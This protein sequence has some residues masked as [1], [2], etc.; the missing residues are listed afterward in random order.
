[1]RGKRLGIAV[2][3]AIVSMLIW[4]TGVVAQDPGFVP[5][6]SDKMKYPEF[7][8]PF[9]PSKPIP[10]SAITRIA[11][12]KD[13]LL[14]NDM[15]PDAGTVTIVFPES[16]MVNQPRLAAGE[17][18]AELVVPTQLLND[19]NRSRRD[20]EIKV[21]LPYYY[22]DGLSVPEDAPETETVKA[23]TDDLNRNDMDYVE[24]EWYEPTGGD[25]ITGA[26]GRMRP[27]LYENEE[28]QYFVSF[29]EI[30]FGDQSTGDWVEIIVD[31]RDFES[32]TRLWFAM[33]DDGVW[34][35]SFDCKTYIDIEDY[36]NY[37][38]YKAHDEEED[39]DYTSCW[40]EYPDDTWLYDYYRDDTPTDTYEDFVGSGE[41]DEIQ[42]WTEDFF[43]RTYYARLEYLLVDGDWCDTGDVQD[44]LEWDH[45]VSSSHVSI[46]DY[47]GST[48]LRFNMATYD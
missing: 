35:Q 3:F 16:W 6:M 14:E 22:F 42:T 30:E 31:M 40:I 29:H 43:L 32:D 21:T 33:Y 36:G 25:D 7:N 12:S 15:E 44:L 23:E 26:R 47:M 8:E 24:R 45:R 41:L 39:Y 2:A 4:S 9:V 19:H 18:A 48:G 13:W 38:V 20:G 27:Y 37:E 28:D 46:T 1:M 34:I 5:S 17:E 11:F 10:E